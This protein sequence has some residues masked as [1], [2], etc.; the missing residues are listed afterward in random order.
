MLNTSDQILEALFEFERTGWRG[1]AGSFAL[2]GWLDD[3]DTLT[4]EPARGRGSCV[5]GS[6]LIPN[7]LED[8]PNHC[9]Y[10]SLRMAGRVVAL[11]SGARRTRRFMYSSA[12]CSC[13]AP[14]TDSVSYTHLTLPTILL[15]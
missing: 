6:K 11:S 7:G 4:L 2:G 3:N 9:G 14:C 13:A 12:F 15:V 5:L 1:C 10:A 8:E